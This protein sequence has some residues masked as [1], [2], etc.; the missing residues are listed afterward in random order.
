MRAYCPVSLFVLIL[1]LMSGCSPKEE[2]TDSKIIDIAAKVGTGEIVNLS[3]IASEIRYVPLETKKESLIDGGMVSMFFVKGHIYVIDNTNVKIFDSNGK[4]LSTINR[5][6]RGPEEY[7]DILNASVDPVNGNITIFSYSGILKEYDIYGNFISSVQIPDLADYDFI[8]C[9][10]FD[11]NNY[12]SSVQ[13]RSIKGEDYSLIVFD[14]QSK[15]KLKIA[16]SASNSELAVVRIPSL[17]RFENKIRIIHRE[18]DMDTVYSLTANMMLEESFVFN[19]GK[20]KMPYN[21]SNYRE[22]LASKTSKNISLSGNVIES[23]NY[24]FLNFNFRGIKS[25]SYERRWNIV[26]GIF[27]KENGELT[28]MKE[29]VKGKLGFKNDI[30]TG[31][32]FWPYSQCF[33]NSLVSMYSADK[34]KSFAD[35]SVSSANVKEIAARLDENDNPVVV[36]VKLK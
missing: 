18:I 22:T 33:D 11:D 4:Y 25:E 8:N 32:V 10:K 7:T 9:M 2:K 20:Y 31:L 36:I 19:Y 15:I 28:L 21:K 12:I 16:N 6:G 17:V 1:L 34:F 24:L 26:C 35:S 30:D 23:E 27:N 3:K 29:P 5:L 14:S 13:Q